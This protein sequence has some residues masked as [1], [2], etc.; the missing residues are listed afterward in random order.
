MPCPYGIDI[1]AILLHYNK[2]VNEGEIAQSIESESYKKARRA[3]LVSY[4]RAVPKL[5]Q[6]D[7]CIGCGQCEGH[8]PQSI[9]IP[10]ELH[11]ISRY[12]EKLKQNK[13]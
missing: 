1:P 7:R 10:Q 11:K 2:C 5:R 6:A 13:L 4:D 3:Y 12:I 8:C 9:K